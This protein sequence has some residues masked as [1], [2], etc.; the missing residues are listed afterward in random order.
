MNTSKQKLLNTQKY[1]ETPKG[2]LTNLYGKMKE[3]NNAKGFGELPFSLK[4]LHG[5]YIKNNDFINMVEQWKA[6]GKKSKDKPSFDRINPLIGYTLKNIQLKTW[7]ENR[8]KADWEKSFIYTTAVVMLDINMKKIR[9]FE[10]VKE[11][12]NATGFSQGNIVMCCQGKRKTVKGYIF[13]YRGDKFKKN[14]IHENPEL[15]K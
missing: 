6:K 9:E 15:L 10:S 4:D 13:R 11:V 7:G 5:L 12:V 14:N 3:R 1:R 2:I 8:V